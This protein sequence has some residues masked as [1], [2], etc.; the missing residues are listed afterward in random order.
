VTPRALAVSAFFVVAL[1]A[2]GMAFG[3]SFERAAFLAPV[4]VVVAGGFAFLVV[5]WAKV[6][7][8]SLRDRS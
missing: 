3:L 2:G 1:V 5:L 6:I 7:R 8:E 4:L